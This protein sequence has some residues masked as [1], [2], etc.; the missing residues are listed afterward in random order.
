VLKYEKKRTASSICSSCCSS[1]S[2]N[3]I[4]GIIWRV[5]LYN[6]INVRE[7]EASLSYISA[8]KNSSFSLAKFKISRSS[9]LLFLLSMNVLDWDVNVIQK[10]TVEFDSITARHEDHYLLLEVLSKESKKE[11]EFNFWFFDN[12]VALLEV[13]HSFSLI[14]LCDFNKYWVLQRQS[15][16]IFNFFSH[17]C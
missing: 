7:I 15:N 4:T 14:F 8:E 9:L 1:Y 11:L 2:M 12:D 17:C 3:I 5:E 6:P 16:Q 10:V 13:I